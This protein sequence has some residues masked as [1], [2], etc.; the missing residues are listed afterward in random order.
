MAKIKASDTWALLYKFDNK[1]PREFCEIR[2][3]GNEVHV[4][5]GGANTWGECKVKKLATPEKAQA[6]FIKAVEK[7][8]D[9]GYKL[10]R[11]AKYDPDVFDYEHLKNEIRDGAR[12]AFHACREA[13][14]PEKL[15]AFGILS[16]DDCITIVPMAESHAESDDEDD[17]GLIWEMCDWR[18]EDGGE[19]LDFA[20]RLILPVLNLMNVPC[21]VKFEDYKKNFVECCVAAL[22]ELDREGLFGKGKDRENFVVM[23]QISDSDKNFDKE[24]R[25]L[26][27]PKRYKEYRKYV[28]GR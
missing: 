24:L 27:T 23:F 9:D 7:A 16:D 28:T 8:I 19:Y 21:N 18:R 20:Y 4:R 6:A 15:V 17:G 26:N 2:L 12:Q 14:K 3:I 25:R 10:T 13:C 22:E 1:M 11:Q 5:T